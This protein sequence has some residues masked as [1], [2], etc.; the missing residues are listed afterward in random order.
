MGRRA[1]QRAKQR[2]RRIV[3][4]SIVVAIIAVVVVLTLV[5]EASQND[6][7][8]KYIGLPVSTSV[9]QAM[10]GVNDSTLS[11][12]GVPSGVT[13]PAA[14]TGP[15]LTVGGKPEVLYV[16]GDFCPYCAVE[17]WS[18]IIALSHF[19]SFSGLEYMQSSSGDINANTPTFTFSNSTYTSQY[20]AF[21]PIE[22]FNRATSTITTLNSVETSL[23]SSYD[24]CGGSSSGSGGIPFVDIA[25]SWAVNCGAQTTIDIGGMNWTAVA[26]VLNNPNNNIA[27]QLDGTANTLITAICKVDGGQPTS[28]CSQSYADVTLGY[29]TPAS[30]TSSLQGTPLLPQVR[31]ETRW[32]GS[33][34]RF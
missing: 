30:G 16:G 10:T 28:V 18:L 5:V 15:A 9:L 21:L 4:V 32:I 14:V 3:T 34:S 6:P 1:T 29:L 19:G 12:I 33:P 11:T 27:Q 24:S 23:V 2:N 17:R 8:A 13:P 20:I 26:S 31:E 7:G 22:E 25:N